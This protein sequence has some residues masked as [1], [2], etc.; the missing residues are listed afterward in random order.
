MS[1][2]ILVIVAFQA[3]WIQKLY[4]DEWTSVK[5]RSDILLK[6]T[7]Q[8]IIA[9]R[10]KKNNTFFSPEGIET[11]Q[12]VN[13]QRMPARKLHNKRVNISI[14][15]AFRLN[16]PKGAKIETMVYAADSNKIIQTSNPPNI[17][18]IV[19]KARE[20][21]RPVRILI[22]DST[23]KS[24][25]FTFRNRV[26]VTASAPANN[27]KKDS[28][29][30]RNTPEQREFLRF[31]GGDKNAFVSD[32][33][34]YRKIIVQFNAI[35]D[36][37][38]MKKLDSHYHAALKKEGIKLKYK[39]AVKKFETNKADSASAKELKTNYALVGFN[40][41]YGYQASF[42][43]PFN[44]ILGKLS[45]QILISLF[46]IA[47]TVVSFVSLYRNLLAQQK[48]TGIKNDFISNITH[49]LKTPIATVGVAIEA[50]RNFNAIK[51]PAKTKEYLDISA[52]ELQRLSL[53]VDKVLK[54]SMFENREVELRKEPFD[55]KHLVDEVAGT[56]RLQFEKVKA[57]VT[58]SADMNSHIVN[59]DKLHITSVVYNLLDNALKYSP[60]DPKIKV[61]L[62]SQGHSIVLR[63]SD[64]GI[65]IASDYKDKIFEKF[66]RVP[67]NDHHNIKGY[68]LGLSYV[69]HVVKKHDGE[70]SVESEPG[71][72]S[73]FTVKLPAA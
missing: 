73:I 51:D 55:L 19:A 40:K 12:V 4:N 58:I 38:P 22:N 44:F 34:Q 23:H 70:I 14:P 46:L 65:G 53:L 67:A 66:F 49:E 11:I 28:I 3:Y 41:P 6:E 52:S 68:G 17:D 61:E 36:S 16:P 24:G 64:N 29:V 8:K 54:L 20:M 60:N 1:A 50:L 59:A 33:A 25:G 10:L 42:E 56:M 31:A 43:N 18:S 47:I 13:S 15:G 21:G 72:G 7:V 37:I 39:L 63:V 48:L 35:M 9:E 30:K 57:V 71:V 2:T 32:S 26:E 69:C 5:K 27:N 45:D 62:L